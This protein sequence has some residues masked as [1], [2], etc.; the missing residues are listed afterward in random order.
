MFAPDVYIKNGDH[1]LVFR[2]EPN[3]WCGP[4]RVVNVGNKVSYTDKND[5]IVQQSIDRFKPY[6]IS[7]KV[8]EMIRDNDYIEEAELVNNGDGIQEPDSHFWD[9]NDENV[10][11]IMFVLRTLDSNDPLTKQSEY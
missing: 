2:D 5:R 11:P 7:E 6:L 1:V 3:Y 10:N 9:F 4:F 8:P